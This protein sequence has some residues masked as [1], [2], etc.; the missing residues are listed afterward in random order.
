MTCGHSSWRGFEDFVNWWCRERA[1]FWGPGKDRLNK[2]YGP[3]RVLF[4]GPLGDR[5]VPA[6]LKGEFPGDYGWVRTV[7]LP[8]PFFPSPSPRLLLPVPLLATRST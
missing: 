6:Y 7:A 2:W 3:D 4:L 8:I 5:A 1:G